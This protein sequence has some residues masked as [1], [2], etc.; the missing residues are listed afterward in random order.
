MAAYPEQ[1]PGYEEENQTWNGLIGMLQQ[2]TAE[3]IIDLLTLT[4]DRFRVTDFSRTVY[5]DR[6][7]L[8]IRNNM[9]LDHGWWLMMSA[10][11]W[12]LWLA[13]TMVVIL[14]NSCLFLMRH[15]VKRQTTE[16]SHITYGGEVHA[17]L[18]S[19]R[20]L[21]LCASLVFV[22]VQGAYCARVV[23]IAA[24]VTVQLPFSGLKGVEPAG[25]SV[26]VAPGTST[27]EHFK[28]WSSRALAVGCSVPSVRRGPPV[29]STAE[30]LAQLCRTR[31]LCLLEQSYT[32][33]CTPQPCPVLQVPAAS[34]AA[35][36]LG[37]VLNKGSP[38][39]GII[40]YQL[41]GKL[42]DT[43]QSVPFIWYEEVEL[44][45]PYPGR[46]N[47]SGVWNGLIGALKDEQVD[48]SLDLLTLTSPRRTAADF[49]QPVDY[50]WCVQKPL[51]IHNSA[52]NE[53]KMITDTK[54]IRVEALLRG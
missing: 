38:F 11:S 29:L 16:L 31:R 54:I 53:E 3:I 30:A 2:G 23:S 15:V 21:C 41:S 40:S 37:F 43:V 9:P 24:V 32:V 52:E 47:S 8:F 4:A 36:H 20:L 35:V 18:D 19:H 26:I 34:V 10:F 5:E 28:A 49:L 14:Q 7:V 25:Y 1:V 17:R 48:M 50:D 27:D 46:A 45:D 39:T 51:S 12:D 33:S 42:I 6:I 44:N 22:T 13:V